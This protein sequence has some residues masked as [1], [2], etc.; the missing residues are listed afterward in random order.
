MYEVLKDIANI[1]DYV[2]FR[3]RLQTYFTDKAI[4]NYLG[5][6]LGSFV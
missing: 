1:N 4:I 2:L 3:K 5:E 6:F